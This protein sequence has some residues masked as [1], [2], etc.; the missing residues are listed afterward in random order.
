MLAPTTSHRSRREIRLAADSLVD[1]TGAPIVLSTPPLVKSAEPSMDELPAEPDRSMADEQLISM[2]VNRARSEGL[3]PTGEGGLL[4]QPTERMPESAAGRRDHHHLVAV[5]QGTDPRGDLRP[6]GRGLRS[7][8]DVLGIWA[9]DR[10]QAA[11]YTI[12]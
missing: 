10:L 3:Q 11:Q 6:P 9:G 1:S 12:V 8:R 5:G 4:P 2:L 7:R